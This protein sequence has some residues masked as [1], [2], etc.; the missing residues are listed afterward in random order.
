MVQRIADDRVVRAQ[1]RLKQAAVSVE[2]GRIQ[3]GVF[4]A[5]EIADPRFQFLVDR[6]RAADKAHRRHAVT[7][8]IERLVR[9]GNN[10]GV[11]RQPEVVIRAQVQYV[12]GLAVAAHVDIGLLRAGDE[13]LGLEKSL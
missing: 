6:L 1:Q 9:R 5:Q 8:L 12:L 4:S 2:T 3:N 7:E 13:P 10:F 11:I